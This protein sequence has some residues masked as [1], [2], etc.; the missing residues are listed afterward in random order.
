MM[1]ELSPFVTAATAPASSMPASCSRSRSNP[2]PTI[3][4]PLN[5]AGSRR[6]A[7]S[8]RSMMATV[9]PAA[10]TA[11]A[12]PEPT[13]PQPTTTTCTIPPPAPPVGTTGRTVLRGRPVRET[14]DR[15]RT[16]RRMRVAITGSSGLIGTAL[17]A[18]LRADRHDVLRVVRSG[19]GGAGT[20]QWDIEEGTIDAAAL[21][22]VD[23]VVHLAGEGIAEKRWSDEQRTR[24]LES[25]SKGT[26][27]LASTLAGLSSKPAGL[28]SGSAHGGGGGPGGEGVARKSAPGA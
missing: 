21:E 9:W 22:G 7:V 23:A 18:S 4:L 1:F 2:T 16:V 27:L 26:T 8:L 12:R 13:R 11:V 6:N 24:I 25:R 28:L 3:F 14:A 19:A 15:V 5:P 10:S 20:V 17:A